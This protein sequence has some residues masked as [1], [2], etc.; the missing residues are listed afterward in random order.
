MKN[1][2]RWLGIMMSVILAVN[3]LQMFVYASEAGETAIEAETES[4]RGGIIDVLE[5]EDSEEETVDEESVEN[6]D[7]G[8]DPQEEITDTDESVSEDGDSAESIEDQFVDSE[9]DS[10]EVEEEDQDAYEEASGEP[11]VQNSAAETDNDSSETETE[12]A[13]VYELTQEQIRE[14]QQ[15]LRIWKHENQMLLVYHAMEE[16]QTAQPEFGIYSDDADDPL[17]KGKLQWDEENSLFYG[18]VDFDEMDADIDVSDVPV[19][20]V[21]EIEAEQYDEK[22]GAASVYQ[23]EELISKDTGIVSISDVDTDTDDQI[24]VKWDI[25]GDTAIDGF[26]VIV[27]GREGDDSVLVYDT[28]PQSDG[29][30]DGSYSFDL[31]ENQITIDILTES[32]RDISVAAYKYDD[33]TGMKQYGEAGAYD[34]TES[35]EREGEDQ[36]SEQGEDQPDEQAEDQPGAE[37]DNETVSEEL[38]TEDSSEAMMGVV[39]SGKCGDNL[40][41]ELDGNGTLTISGTGSMYSYYDTPWK[42][43]TVKRVVISNG[44]TDVGGNAFFGCTSLTSVTIPDSVTS[45][46]YDAFEECTSLASVTIPDSVTSIGRGAFYSCTSLTKITIP[47]GVKTIEKNTFF[48]CKGL[49]SVTIPGSVTWI[50]NGVFSGCTSL[51]NIEIPES[52]GYLGDSVFNNCTS[53]SS[54]EIPDNVSAIGMY[55]FYG[56]TSL[57]NVMIPGSVTRILAFTFNGCTNLT[58]VTIPKSVTSIKNDAFSKCDNLEVVYY[59]GS[60]SDWESISIMGYNNPL[61]NAEIVYGNAKLELYPEYSMDVGKGVIINATYTSAVGKTIKASY[62]S[63]AGDALAYNT[64]IV[65]G[66]REVDSKYET[67]ISLIVNGVKAGSYNFTLKASDGTTAKTV[68]KVNP[69][70]ISNATVKLNCPDQFDNGCDCFPYTGK[71]VKPEISEVKVGIG[72]LAI[73]TDYTISYGQNINYGEASVTIKGKGNYFGEKTEK[74]MIVPAKV[75]NIRYTD[76]ACGYNNNNNVGAE[77]RSLEMEWDAG[78]KVSGYWVEYSEDR[79]FTN[80]TYHLIDV[81]TN[82]CSEAGLKRNTKYYVRI[83]AYIYINKDIYFGEYSDIKEY[84]ACDHLIVKDFWGFRNDSCVISRSYSSKYYTPAQ[85]NK[86]AEDG[87]N[88]EEGICY[89]MA[90]LPIATFFYDYPPFSLFNVNSLFDIKSIEEDPLVRDHVFLTHI[91]Q[92]DDLDRSDDGN[93]N[94]NSIDILLSRVEEYTKYGGHPVS[95]TIGKVTDHEVEKEKDRFEWQHQLV[96][97]DIAE[98]SD[99]KVLIRVYDPNCPGDD[100]FLEVFGSNGNY[101]DWEYSSRLGTLKGNSSITYDVLFNQRDILIN[102]E[103]RECNDFFNVMEKSRNAMIAS[104]LKEGEGA[105][106]QHYYDWLIYVSRLNNGTEY[107]DTHNSDEEKSFIDYYRDYFLKQYFGSELEFVGAEQSDDEAGLFFWVPK[108]SDNTLNLEGAPAG[109]EIHIAGNTHAVTVTTTDECDLSICV[110]ETGDGEVQV[111]TDDETEVQAVF[112]DY[113]DDGDRTKTTH[114]ATVNAETPVTITKHSGDESDQP[115]ASGTCGDDMTW[116]LDDEGTLRIVGTGRMGSYGTYIKPPWHDYQQDIKS[117]IIKSGVTTISPYAFNGCSNL[118][119]L[120]IPEGIQVI[121]FRTFTNCTCLT[122]L[123]FPSTTR[124]IMSGTFSGCASLTSVTLPKNVTIISSFGTKGSNPFT[125]CSGLTYVNVEAG[126][127]EFSSIDGVLF[128]KDCTVLCCYPAGRE[129]DYF[130]P[131]GTININHNSFSGSGRLTSIV[132]P[133]S[134]KTIGERAFLKCDN[135]S[136]IYY[137]GTREEWEAIDIGSDNSFLT[138]A[139]I[140]F[141]NDPN[142]LKYAVVSGLGD[143]EYSGKPITSR[144]TVK[145]LGRELDKGKDYTISYSDNTNAGTAKVIITGKG[146]YTGTIEKEFKITPKKITPAVTLNGT[147]FTYT[148][149][150]LKPAVTVKDGDTVLVSGTDYKISYTNNTNAGTA[151]VGITCVGNYTGAAAKSFT[152][153]KAPN[154]ISAKNVAKSYSAWAQSFDLGV[155]VKSGTPTYKSNNKS[156]TVSK[157]GRVKVKAKFIGNATIT[158]KSPANSNYTAATKSIVVKVVPTKTKFTSAT[159]S[160][161]KKMTLKWVK[162]TNATGYIIQ[163]STSSTF[164]GAKTVRVEKNTIVSRTIGNLVKGKRYFV[165]IKT[166]K[167][168]NKV[169]YYSGW[170][171]VKSV[172]IVK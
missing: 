83:K 26:S 76:Y 154:A 104:A 165:R 33:T 41:W 20:V 37:D 89:G 19:R 55:A 97:L 106:S 117:V 68:I 169:K 8:A 35:K 28:E 73:N 99:S 60:R 29:E 70:D 123:S 166:Y 167:T 85:A 132:I 128:N 67:N 53:L 66:P 145:Q 134:V 84:Q 18:G 81:N 14:Y 138:E 108:T 101:T 105:V 9:P 139:E 171:D 149:K 88:G 17:Y 44:V 110:P 147:S 143:Q 32:V 80:S 118:R 102:D 146:K 113:D 40:T 164:A 155:K 15:R 79:A 24:T 100:M 121:P 148:G 126:N 131:E 39:A 2:K 141:V 64:I 112:Y 160:A 51:T 58:S 153:K 127:T 116:T 144:L 137:I 120:K 45:I 93:Y 90:N 150:A 61:L 136:K 5:D 46:G 119:S 21:F 86:L 87:P 78:N 22:N 34:L 42:N 158:I 57:T 6:A 43:Y 129:G 133:S 11:E 162:R 25:T 170:S 109:S 94:I 12:T 16:P 125:N 63:D 92:C 157:T 151:S 159:N 98:K 172:K 152:I 65:V 4:D 91:I 122:D 114:S 7:S 77:H 47:E 168:V 3:S 52:V 74:F 59:S 13:S 10:S 163:Y 31:D 107:I 1:L 115:I 72:N 23:F 48:N 38:D 103:N 156:V 49:T 130:V 95:L 56:C 75:K 96:V 111:S 62:Q 82:N 124:D 54:V 27:R 135:L 50:D 36:P 140:V 30:D 161:S 142:A 71:Q 69:I